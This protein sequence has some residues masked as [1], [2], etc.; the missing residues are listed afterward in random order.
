MPPPLP[1]HILAQQL[2]ALALQERGIGR[3][4]WLAWVGAVTAFRDLDHALVERVVAWML[5]REILWD[6]AGL[7]WLGREGQDTFGRKNSS[8]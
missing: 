5:D 4:E 2:L 7:L 6:D 3:G 8:T 1:L